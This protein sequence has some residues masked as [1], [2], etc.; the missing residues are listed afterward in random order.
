[1]EL[2][3]RTARLSRSRSVIKQPPRRTRSAGRVMSFD[4]L[5]DWLDT[6]D[7]SAKVDGASMLDGL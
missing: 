1:M 4:Q 7:A 2:E 6:L 5:D 3:S